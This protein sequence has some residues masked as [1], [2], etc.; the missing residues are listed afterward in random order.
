[1]GY[2][3]TIFVL[4][5]AFVGYNLSCDFVS[6]VKTQ[7]LLFGRPIDGF[8]PKPPPEFAAKALASNGVTTGWFTQKLDHFD[9]SV[10]ATWSQV[11]TYSLITI[12]QIDLISISNRFVAVS[13]E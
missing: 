3:S 8:V 2:K 1:M 6:V 7:K 4:L 12:S 11:R 9:P 13:K 5:A 10:T